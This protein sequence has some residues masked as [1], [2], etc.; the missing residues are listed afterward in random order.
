VIDGAQQLVPIKV[1]NEELELLHVRPAKFHGDW[2]Y[3]IKPTK[4]AE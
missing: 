3:T 4:M 1:S 2:K